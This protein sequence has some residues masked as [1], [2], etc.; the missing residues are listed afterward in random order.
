MPANH[1]RSKME[2]V[3]SCSRAAS[4]WHHSAAAGKLLANKMQQVKTLKS[5][6]V[7]MY[8]FELICARFHKF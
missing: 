4:L 7:V 5:G 6:A 3:A 8:I 1:K 2:H